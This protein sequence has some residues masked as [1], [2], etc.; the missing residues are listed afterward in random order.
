MNKGLNKTSETRFPPNGSQEQ[1]YTLKCVYCERRYFRADKFSRIKPY[2]YV[3][4]SRGHIFAYFVPK[5]HLTYSDL[6][7]H[8]HHIFADMRPCAKICTARK[9]L[10]LQYAIFSEKITL[11]NIDPKL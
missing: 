11:K 10:R 2:H 5:F 4:F 7:V 3:T 9:F 1:T 8:S 6:N